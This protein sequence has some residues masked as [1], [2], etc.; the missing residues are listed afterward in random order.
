MKHNGEVCWLPKKFVKNVLLDKQM[1]GIII[2]S[3]W[4]WSQKSHPQLLLFIALYIWQLSKTVTGTSWISRYAWN[5][6]FAKRNWIHLNVSL[7]YN[8]TNTGDSS[9]RM[10]LSLSLES[11]SDSTLHRASADWKDLISKLSSLCLRGRT[12]HVFVYWL[13]D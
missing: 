10:M 9:S 8:V 13:N 4:S 7:K 12:I 2:S 11:N 3:T 6:G 1:T 5:G